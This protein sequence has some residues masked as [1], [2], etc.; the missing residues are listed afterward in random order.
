MYHIYLDNLIYRQPV[1]SFEEFLQYIY[2]QQYTED[3]PE[4]TELIARPSGTRNTASE[5]SVHI[6]LEHQL[7]SPVTALAQEVTQVVQQVEQQIANQ[8][9]PFIQ[10]IQVLFNWANR[11]TPP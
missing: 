4:V 2:Y 8:P 3:D 1:P 10:P 11:P 5:E 9:N 6:I 7:T